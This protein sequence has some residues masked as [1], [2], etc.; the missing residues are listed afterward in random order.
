MNPF[1]LPLQFEPHSLYGSAIDGEPMP[2]GYISTAAPMPIFELSTPLK[3]PTDA[4]ASLARQMAAAPQMFTALLAAESFISGFED[5]DLQEGVSPLLRSIRA[6]IRPS[7]AGSVVIVKAQALGKTESL[8]T[9]VQETQDPTIY[10]VT[11]DD[12]RP[13]ETAPK[14]GTAILARYMWLGEHRY[15]VIRRSQN[16]PWWL[17]DHDGLIKHDDD[18]AK[19]SNY[20]FTH[21]CPITPPALD[22]GRDH[23]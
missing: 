6:I 20:E 8:L 1:P 12:W 3:W 10:A 17:A 22:G 5:D 18:K 14:D 21:W 9:I 11:A 15:L 23:G 7:G 2:F 13:I 19:P 16:G 4:L